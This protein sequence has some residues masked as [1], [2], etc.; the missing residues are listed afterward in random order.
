MRAETRHSLKQDKFSKATI[1]AAEK[2][3]HWT[4][5]HQGK[6][7]SAVV[8]LVVVV[9]AA[10]AT[11]YY[12]QQ[13]DLKASTD[14]GKAIRT[15]NAQIRP[16]GVPAQPDVPSFTSTKDRATEAHK[17]FQAIVDKYPHTRASEFARY[18]AG[19]TASELG[20]NAAAERNLKE[21]ASSHHED[22][23]ALAKFALA[24]VYR[25]TN[26]DKEAIDIYKQL[27]NKPTRS[28][29]KATAQ[30]ELADLYEEKQQP[31]EAK[32][33]YQQIQKE[34]PNSEVASLASSKLAGLK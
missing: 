25:K 29:G 28:V 21:V 13:Q 7:I 20:D 34:N 15:L 27:I 2:T 14:F 26:R 31:Q 4:V 33:I 12:L 16:A 9:A 6:I 19:M 10:L 18:F 3:V 8:I 17:E 11:W 32:R 5:E 22:V 23:G 30:L 1:N 24:S